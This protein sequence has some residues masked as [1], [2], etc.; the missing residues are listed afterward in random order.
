M[1]VR[2]DVRFERLLDR[3]IALAGNADEQQV[4]D[5]RTALTT[6]P[7]VDASSHG[8]WS[9]REI[10]DPRNDESG[11]GTKVRLAR[12]SCAAATSPPACRVKPARRGDHALSSTRAA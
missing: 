5:A 4:A 8:G 1:L 11:S 12:K 7:M 6:V 10:C 9:L 3:G 2:R